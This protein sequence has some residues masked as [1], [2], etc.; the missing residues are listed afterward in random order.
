MARH[1]GEAAMKVASAVWK[2]TAVHHPWLTRHYNKASELYTRKIKSRSLLAYR[3][4]GSGNN[5]RVV[6]RYV[7]YRKI[8][9][10]SAFG[11]CIGDLEFISR[12]SE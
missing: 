6:S 12:S 9:P 4:E 3:K 5:C 1:H 11:F 2:K 10:L 8:P 7:T